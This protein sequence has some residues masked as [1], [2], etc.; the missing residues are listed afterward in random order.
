MRTN[1]QE[2]FPRDKICGDAVCT[3]AIHILEASWA[4]GLAAWLLWDAARLP[5]QL[6]RRR[7]SRLPAEATSPFLIMCLLL[8]LACLPLYCMLQEM[9][10][11]DELK[12]ADEVRCGA[13]ACG[14][15]QQAGARAWTSAGR[16]ASSAAGAAGLRMNAMLQKMQLFLYAPRRSALPTTAAL[17]PPPACRTSVRGRRACMPA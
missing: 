9:G 11:I 13:P 2:H 15:W 16:H 3:P 17:C 14:M 6:Q 1:P 7:W 5:L 12:A 4:E 10:V 8:K